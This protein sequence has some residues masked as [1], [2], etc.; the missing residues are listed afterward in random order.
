MSGARPKKAGPC[1]GHSHS[2]GPGDACR[3][4]L[5]PTHT[6]QG[7]LLGDNRSLR[8][9]FRPPACPAPSGVPL[10]GLGQPGP[11]PGGRCGLPCLTQ[12][13]R[14]LKNRNPQP[15]LLGASSSPT[16]AVGHLLFPSAQPTPLNPESE[17]PSLTALPPRAGRRTG[18]VTVTAGSSGPAGRRHPLLPS[19]PSPASTRAA[20]HAKVPPAFP[21]RLLS[22]PASSHAGSCPRCFTLCGK[23]PTLVLSARAWGEAAT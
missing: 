9:R 17:V 10:V 11:S 13:R 19:P 7:Q 22:P 20:Q 12:W 15:A 16:G 3:Q 23:A 1:S 4:S 8:P 6:G 21:C 14:R 5:C 2:W 18:P